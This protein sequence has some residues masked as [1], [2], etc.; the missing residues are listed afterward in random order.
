MTRKRWFAG[1]GLVVLIVLASIAG[2]PS[3]AAED[4]KSTVGNITIAEN[5]SFV[6]YTYNPTD[7]GVQ[8]KVAMKNPSGYSSTTAQFSFVDAGETEIDVFPCPA[9]GQCEGVPIVTAPSFIVLSGSY[10]PSGS[11]TQGIHIFP[12]DWKV[13]G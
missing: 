13:M 2:Q 7:E 4:R 12:T 8:I 1:L 6:A 3:R 10:V 11:V 9:V 5:T